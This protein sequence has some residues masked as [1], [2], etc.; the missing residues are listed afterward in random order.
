MSSGAPRATWINL[1]LVLNCLC[2]PSFIANQSGATGFH[3]IIDCQ[4]VY[5]TGVLIGDGPRVCNS[6]LARNTT[7]LTR[8]QITATS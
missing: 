1:L 6:A 5:R 3:L 7:I 4:A 2:A 8:V